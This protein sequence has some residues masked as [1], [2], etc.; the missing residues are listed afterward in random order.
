[1]FKNFVIFALGAAVGS[2]VTSR[3]ITNKAREFADNEIKDMRDYYSERY[4]EEYPGKT[5][6]DIPVE[7]ENN[8]SDDKEEDVNEDDDDCDPAEKE[9]PIEELWYDPDE[10]EEVLQAKID[11]IIE[12]E[13]YANKESEE[14]KMNYLPPYPIP[15][16]EFEN[17]YG[18]ETLSY[19]T[20]GM[21]TD[22]HGNI[23]HN[24]K[25]MLG[26]DILSHFCKFDGE[27]PSIAY[28]R[29]DKLQMDYEILREPISLHSL[30]EYGDR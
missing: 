14:N 24:H 19:W 28:V 10:P 1:M 20:D 9:S 8:S 25:E 5:N 13:G 3:L 17:Y 18:S 16:E 4:G 12:Q 27:D 7:T 29:N 23:V 6:T 22:L 11:K 30:G 15:F 21:V 2:I 26:D